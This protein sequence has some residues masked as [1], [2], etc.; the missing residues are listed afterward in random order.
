MTFFKNMAALFCFWLSLMGVATAQTVAK[1]T[2]PSDPATTCINLARGGPDVARK[3]AAIMD[4]PT[5]ILTA[6]VVPAGGN[7]NV[8]QKDW[9]EHCRVEGQIAPTIGFELRMPT[10]TWNGKFIM[11]GCGGPCGMYLTDRTDPALVRNYAVVVTDMGHKGA[12]WMFADNN[13]EGMVDFG[14]RSTHVTS[15]AAKEIIAAFYGT[16]ASRNYFIGCSTGGRQ[17]LVE[18]QRFP[19]DFD[20]IAAGAP[21]FKQTGHQPYAMVW[22]AASNMKD[23]KPIMDRSKLPMLH[24][25]VLEKCDA[26]D[27][28]ADGILQNPAACTFQPTDI[29]CKAGSD[30]ENCLT[31]DEATVVAK[32][33]QGPVNSKGILL[34]RGQARG[35][36]LGWGSAF[37]GDNG[38]PGSALDP[39][40]TTLHHLAFLPSPGP[41]YR[42]SQFDYDRDPPRLA[43]NDAFFYH[44]NPDLSRLRDNGRKLIFYMGW[45]DDNFI[46]PE[47]AIDY[48]QT[49]ERTMGGPEK[50]REFARLFMVPGMNHCRGGIG[51]G[52]I[53][54]ITALENWV[55]KGQ[56][57]EQVIAYHMKD[58]YPAANGQQ[59]LGRHPLDPSDYDRSRPV[60]AYPAVAQYKGSGDPTKPES[61]KKVMP[62][63]TTTK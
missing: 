31:A 1:N 36:E 22:P 5:T 54:W 16:K 57:P 20:G 4:A 17:G 55:E 33:Y 53:D 34:H 12:G 2:G 51:G 14:Y 19:E 26:L 29:L 10:K 35:S 44:N 60:Y 40:D 63:A 47:L 18:A 48:F 8:V 50:T 56:A 59:R 11:G 15:I 52:E 24:K 25:A 9:P 58:A 62:A 6:V 45:N 39:A 49:V 28:L 30:T 37:L 43:A 3:F 21:P 32:I 42:V 41:G 7:G 61:W 38:K 27:G 46:P 13:L 23:G